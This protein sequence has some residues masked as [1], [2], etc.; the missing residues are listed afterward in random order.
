MIDDEKLTTG[1]PFLFLCLL[2]PPYDEMREN[3]KDE[4][5]LLSQFL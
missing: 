2:C 3:L 1:A 4:T 5:L